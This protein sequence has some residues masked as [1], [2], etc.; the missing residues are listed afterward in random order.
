MNAL[1]AVLWRS[2]ADNETDEN[3]KRSIGIRTVNFLFTL[4]RDLIAI[5]LNK[6]LSA[7]KN[8]C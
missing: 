8:Y 3:K 5:I 2:P 6:F 1:A 4:L 7:K